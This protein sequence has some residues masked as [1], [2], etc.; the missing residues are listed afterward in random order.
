MKAHELL[1]TA[2]W[3]HGAFAR[4]PEGKP[5]DPSDPQAC[6]FCLVGAILRCYPG[7]Q[8]CIEILPR[9]RR[10]LFPGETTRGALTSWNDDPKRTKTEVLNLLESQDL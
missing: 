9:L 5:T 4:T 10:L 1:K 6:E 8:V 3:T 2:G 7:P